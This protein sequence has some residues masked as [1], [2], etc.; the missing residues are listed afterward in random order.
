MRLFNA[1][2]PGLLRLPFKIRLIIVVLLFLLCFLF[3][4]FTQ[5]SG[6]LFA[7]PI[8]LTAWFFR[9]R[10]ALISV[11]LTALALAIAITVH[12][13]GLSWSEPVFLIWVTGVLTLLIEGFFI[14]YLRY[15]LDLAESARAQVQQAEQQRRLAYEL[16][17]EAQRAEERMTSAYEQ[18]RELNQLKDQF[19][20]NVNHELRSP[21]TAL[22]GWLEVLSAFH[23]QL[24]AAKQL[25]YLEKAKESCEVLIH[26]VNTV[27]DTAQVD[28]AGKPAQ[29][30]SCPVGQVVRDELERLDPRETNDFV[31]QLDIAEQLTVLANQQYLRQILR[32]LLSNAFK[33]APR[34]TRVVVSAQSVA[35]STSETISA[36]N[37]TIC[38]SDTG[39][40]IP[41]AEQPL[42]FEKFVR[43]KRDHSLSMPGSGLGLY[44]SKQLVESMGGRMW[45]ES[46]GLPGEGCRFY[47]TLPGAPALAL[48]AP[49]TSETGVS[50]PDKLATS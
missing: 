38:V 7:L 2:L 32:N 31:I 20:L 24:D 23:Q 13:R 26:L 27:L 39:P 28:G 41:L 29:V 10:G 43:L 47:F 19:I 3:Y 36:R 9:R 8:A 6:S 48:P 35:T 44:I 1:L 22:Y 37:V 16:Q 18:Q 11:G 45:V 30:E 21:L 50:V 34:K 42:L 5:F 4:I 40:G 15:L 12:S 25:A 33:Y 49:A 46:S 14:F 17:V